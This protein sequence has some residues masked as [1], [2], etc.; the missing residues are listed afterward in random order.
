M[1]L[2]PQAVRLPAADGLTLVGSFYTIP[3]TQAPTILLLHDLNGSRSNWLAL[4]EPLLSEGYNALLVDMRGH[5]E[6]GGDQNWG[7]AIDDVQAWLDWLQEQPEV[8]TNGVS[9]IGADLGGNLAL[10]A[11]ENDAECLTAI[12]LSPIAVGCNERDCSEEAAGVPMADIALLDGMTENTIT[13]SSR[14]SD[15]LLIAGVDDDI[16]LASIRYIGSARAYQV[17]FAVII[18]EESH[19][20]ELLE[21]ALEDILEP[22]IRWLGARTPANLTPD[23]IE[24]LV[25]A[26]DP[27]NGATLFAEGIIGAPQEQGRPCRQCH[28]TD[29]EEK[30]GGG[31]GLLNVGTRAASRLDGQSA[32]VYLYDSIVAPEMFVVDDY[33]TSN[34]PWA[35]DTGFTEEEIADLVAYLLTL[36]AD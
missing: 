12:A 25:A 8:Q 21:D 5:G 20:T 3:D 35:Y 6:T 31:P 17:E 32:A 11:C 7:A 29:S 14:R 15:A 26:A 33:I 4:V 19:G 34:M 28:M 22:T 1:S 10:I 27:E 18:G 24:A 23:A 2:D 9:I 30:V 13:V 16:S 36:E